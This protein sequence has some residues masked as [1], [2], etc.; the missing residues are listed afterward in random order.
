DDYVTKPFS[1]RELLARVKT[2]LRRSRSLPRSATTATPGRHRFDQWTLDTGRRELVGADG[3]TV[4]LSTTEIRLLSVFL[5]RPR[6]VPSP[7]Q[8]PDVSPAC[9]MGA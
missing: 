1:P 8:R 9:W 7:G 5:E 3:V 4:P 2:V 6:T